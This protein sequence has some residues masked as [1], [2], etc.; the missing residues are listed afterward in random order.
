[1]RTRFPRVFAPGPL[2]KTFQFAE[3]IV[4]K[5][6]QNRATQ[7][8]TVDQRGVTEFVEQN[9]VIFGDQGGNGP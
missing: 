5:D 9:D 8:C 6:P 4:W 2:E 7:F 3:I 1:M